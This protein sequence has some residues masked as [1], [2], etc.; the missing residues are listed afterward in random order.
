MIQFIRCNVSF[1]IFQDNSKSKT[2]IDVK[3]KR[4][5]FDNEEEK[6]EPKEEGELS[7]E[8]DSNQSGCSIFRRA[9]LIATDDENSSS[10]YSESDKF[11][12]ETY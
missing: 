10:A 5:N 2:D 7:D 12:G 9:R 4:V 11:S 6:D 3:R 1:F 8:N